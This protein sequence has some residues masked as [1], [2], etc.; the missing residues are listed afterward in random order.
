MTILREI[1]FGVTRLRL[2]NS[3]F[4]AFAPWKLIS[5]KISQISTLWKRLASFFSS[6][7]FSTTSFSFYSLF[8][9]YVLPSFWV[10]FKENFY[11]V[12]LISQKFC[13]NVENVKMIFWN[14]VDYS[15]TVWKNTKLSYTREIR[16][17][18]LQCNLLWK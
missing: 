2:W 7:L 16:E 9:Y 6:E 1:D 8:L 3:K 14:L 13:K 4:D 12:W 5:R 17:N 15:F 10:N 11:R 18:S